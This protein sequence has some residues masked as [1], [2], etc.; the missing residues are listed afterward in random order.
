MKIIPLMLFGL[1]LIHSNLALAKEEL[2]A[3]PINSP[4]KEAYLKVKLEGFDSIS[5]VLFKPKNGGNELFG[6][7]V[8]EGNAIIGKFKVSFLKPG[9][10]E[11]RIKVR[12][13]SGKS[14]QDEAASVAFISFKVD[15]S[16]G[17]ADPGEN[18]N[19]TLAGIDSDNDGVRD[20]AQRWI[21]ETYPNM[22]STKQALYQVAKNKQDMILN[23]KNREHLRQ[24]NAPE[25]SKSIACFSWVTS[26]NPK[27]STSSLDSVLAN[28]EARVMAR[29]EAESQFG[30]VSTPDEVVQTKW[31]DLKK[32]CK[33]PASQE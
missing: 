28:T 19:K 5:E 24:V 11:Y 32:F 31:I 17:V 14:Q 1:L 21:N 13:A 26:G 18:G 15:S 6:E 33:F 25:V 23:S 30:G 2:V 3:S 12:T 29:L 16:L 4:V 9:T 10:Y 8:K 22:P 7:V 27:Y 20:D